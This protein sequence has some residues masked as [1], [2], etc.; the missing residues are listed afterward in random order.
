[1]SIDE[2]RKRVYFAVPILMLVLM[3][4]IMFSRVERQKPSEYV[5]TAIA[6][7]PAVEENDVP[8]PLVEPPSFTLVAVGDVMLD[9]KVGKKIEN[10]GAEFPFERVAELL[11]EA[12]LTFANL[13]SPISSLG[14]AVKGKEVTFRAALQAVSGI[15]DVGIDVLS[16]ANNHAMDYGSAALIETMD[17]LAHNGIA[18]IGAGAN[19]AAAHRPANLTVEGIKVSLLAYSYRFHMVV[20][21]QQEH[22]GVAIASGEAVKA[23]I[24]RAKEWAD[25]VIVSFHWGW[26]Y[27]DHPDEETRKL[28]HLAVESGASLVIG[29][30]P[31]VIQGVEIYRDGLICYSLGNF[32]FDQQGTRTRRGLML[33][34]VM[35]RSGIQKAEFLPVI[36]DA[37]SYRPSLVSGEAA[38]PILLELRRLSKQLDTELELKE[39]MAIILREEAMLV[40]A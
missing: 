9:R 38:K 29:H 32:I 2:I 22:P 1:M 15:R 5:Q 3:A 25:I 18:Y 34:C 19:S 27:S 28:A 33:R 6:V 39:N 7:E 31:H 30:H 36:I 8:E 23:D 11:R 12:D 4:A 14:T 10:L 17:V 16:L 37:L 26:E 21:A 40:G 24:E 35:G 20:E 13:E